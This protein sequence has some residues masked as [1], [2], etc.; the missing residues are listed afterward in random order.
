MVYCEN[1]IGMDSSLPTGVD[2]YKLFRFTRGIPFTKDALRNRAKELVLVTHPDK[3][4][5]SEAK[6]QI[7]MESY[8]Y[9]T[10]VYREFE[11]MSV[12]VDEDAVRRHREERTSGKEE[13]EIPSYNYKRFTKPVEENRRSTT[14]KEPTPETHFDAKAFNKFFEENRLDNSLSRG[15]GEWLKN[16]DPSRESS[17]SRSIEKGRFQEE[18]EKERQRLLKEKRII[19]HTGGPQGVSLRASRVAGSSLDELGDA[20]EGG[21]GTYRCSNGVMGVDLREALEVG[22]IAVDD[23]RYSGDSA[24]APVSIKDAERIRSE[25]RL[26]YTDEETKEMMRQKQ[27]QEARDRERQERIVQRDRQIREH[28]QRVNHLVG[29]K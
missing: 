25:A 12:T 8:R 15:H 1:R 3:P 13:F 7:V 24:S 10:Q 5:G 19:K 18:F 4:G 11:K 9:L 16:P 22:I 29:D 14:G 26:T 20:T 17:M 27:L 21:G 28:F 2:P 23:P 6:F